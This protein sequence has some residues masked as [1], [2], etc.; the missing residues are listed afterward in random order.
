MVGFNISFIDQIQNK[1][2]EYN[3]YIESEFRKVDNI[4]C[5]YPGAF[6]V[7]CYDW[8]HDGKKN[9]FTT[10]NFAAAY[11]YSS[12]SPVLLSRFVSNGKYTMEK[13]FDRNSYY[14]RDLEGIEKNILLLLEKH[15]ISVNDKK[16]ILNLVLSVVKK[17]FKEKDYLSIAIMDKSNI[18]RNAYTN[19]YKNLDIDESINELL[20]PKF[21]LDCHENTRYNQTLIK[22]AK[23]RNYT[24]LLK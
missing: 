24:R 1:G 4:L 16:E 5:K 15:E 19:S 2:I 22:L 9:I 8:L 21:G 23:I 10:D 6:D 17:L 14:N 13:E 11:Y 3:N 7:L 18:N 12:L 20:T